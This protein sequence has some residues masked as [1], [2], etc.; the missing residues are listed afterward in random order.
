MRKQKR[1]RKQKRKRKNGEATARREVY[2]LAH[3]YAP[4]VILKALSRAYDNVLRG[5]R[6][7]SQAQADFFIKCR[8]STANLGSG[9]EKWL[10]QVWDEEAGQ[11]IEG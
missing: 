3:Q 6:F 4:H 9:M 5:H 2:K 1:T 7:S 11:A 10:E 8:Q